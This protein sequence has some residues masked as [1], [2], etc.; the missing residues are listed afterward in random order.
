M[1][2][3]YIPA[4]R[5]V[6]IIILYMLGYILTWGMFFSSTNSGSISSN[7]YRGT[8]FSVK[9]TLVLFTRPAGNFDSIQ[10][11]ASVLSM[12]CPTTMNTGE[13]EG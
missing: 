8:K 4:H 7:C 5:L 10:N 2:G 6:C 1:T 11:K 3:V 12:L 9:M 13:S